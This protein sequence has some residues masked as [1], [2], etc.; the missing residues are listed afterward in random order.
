MPTLQHILYYIAAVLVLSAASFVLYGW[1]KHQANVKGWRVSEKNLHM[2]SLLGGWPGA[3][4][5]QNYFRHKT[6][7]QSFRVT[8]WLT[9]V[10]HVIA[11]GY[12]LY[13]GIPDV[14]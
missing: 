13:N 14:Q 6:Q 3:I 8:F 5:G 1:D 2:L 11:V 7:K 10:L 4:L 9:V 12:V